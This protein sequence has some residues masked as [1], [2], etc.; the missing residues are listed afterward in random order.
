MS[1][2]GEEQTANHVINKCPIY[3]PPNG[4]RS[5]MILDEKT[6]SGCSSSALTSNP[7]V[8]RQ[9]LGQAKKKQNIEPSVDRKQWTGIIVC[10]AHC[11]TKS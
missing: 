10:F 2:C 7:G 8:R 1:L 5:L 6:T 4:E 3:N 11:E 9:H